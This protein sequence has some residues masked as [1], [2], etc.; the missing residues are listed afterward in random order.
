MYKMANQTSE[1]VQG[2]EGNFP[3]PAAVL[4]VLPEGAKVVAGE[5]AGTSA[6]TKT[7]KVTVELADGSTKRYFLKVGFAS[8]PHTPSNSP[9]SSVLPGQPPER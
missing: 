2:I 7:A 3:V 6:W 4:A 8:S 5:R 9:P 1:R